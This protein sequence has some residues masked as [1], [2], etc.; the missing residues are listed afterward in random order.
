MNN[1]AQTAN[2][3]KMFALVISLLALVLVTFA[4]YAP[5]DVAA[6]D[7]TSSADSP[8]LMPDNCLDAGTDTQVARNY[9][10]FA[11]CWDLE[12]SVRNY[13]T[14]AG[15]WT[16]YLDN[17]VAVRNYG[18]FAGV[19]TGYLDSAVAQQSSASL[20]ANPELMFARR[21]LAALDSVT[22][23]AMVLVL[24]NTLN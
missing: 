8:K 3:W 23:G 15:V 24:P 19:W 1:Q 5:L 17:V 18:T 22:D 16:G 4:A 11:G 13:G 10:T 7:I 2:L 9:G 6:A 20:A 21:Y 12:E 14:F